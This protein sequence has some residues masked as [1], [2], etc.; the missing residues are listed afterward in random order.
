MTDTPKSRPRRCFM[1]FRTQFD[2]SGFIP[3]LVTEGEAGHAPLVGRGE[4][5]SPWHWG[6]T[7]EEAKAFTARENQR[8]G[9]S[10]LDVIDIIASS[11]GA[12]RSWN[13]AGRTQP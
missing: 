7:Y 12:S 13:P 10:E 4:H 8:L 6:K 11:I 9:L 2:D 5:A 1:V 3:S